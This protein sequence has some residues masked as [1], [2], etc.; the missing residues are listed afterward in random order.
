MLKLAVGI[1]PNV[2]PFDG[3]YYETLKPRRAQ[4]TIFV[5][6]IKPC[7]KSQMAFL[8]M[9]VAKHA[10]SPAA[11]PDEQQH[12]NGIELWRNARTAISPTDQD[13]KAD[14]VRGSLTCSEA[15]PATSLPNASLQPKHVTEASGQAAATHD[16][17]A[18][19]AGG[20]RE[21]KVMF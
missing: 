2:L 19:G 5:S 12:I 9:R 8:Q 13:R 21:A 7:T 1:R 16:A 20:S 6:S 4:R 18:L 3:V 15:L 11:R 17:P 10:G 14:V